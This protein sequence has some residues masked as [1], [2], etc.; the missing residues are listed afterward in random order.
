MAK[1][2]WHSDPTRVETEWGLARSGAPKKLDP[3]TI[4]PHMASRT[5]TTLGAPPTGAPPD[6]SSPLPTDPEKQHGGKTLPIPACHSGTPSGRPNGA[7]Y[8]PQRADLV[9]GE[10]HLSGATKL[11]AETTEE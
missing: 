7:I 4:H 9:I 1:Q 2:T 10:A 6:A 8:D 3:L 5:N 11:P